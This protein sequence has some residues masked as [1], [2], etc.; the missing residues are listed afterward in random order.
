[1]PASVSK[2]TEIYGARG[3]CTAARKQAFPLPAE[4]FYPRKPPV[5]GSF[6]SL[7]EAKAGRAPPPA[8][9]AASSAEKRRLPDQTGGR[10]FFDKTRCY[11]PMGRNTIMERTNM[12]TT[13]AIMGREVRLTTSM[14]LLFTDPATIMTTADTGETARSRLMG[15]PCGR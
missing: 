7:L 3:V 12:N 14:G 13:P 2:R 10:R 9:P 4:V 8:L 5:G 11:A 15:C 6:R 1:M